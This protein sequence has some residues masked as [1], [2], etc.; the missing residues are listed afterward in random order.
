MGGG[1]DTGPS[2]KKKKKGE[3]G[4]TIG[5]WEGQQGEEKGMVFLIKKKAKIKMEKE[6]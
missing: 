3:G 1:G 6:G 2:K 4:G 5:N